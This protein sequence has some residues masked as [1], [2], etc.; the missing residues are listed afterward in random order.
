M[1]QESKPTIVVYTYK[2]TWQTRD[3]NLCV[4]FVTDIPAGHKAFEDAIKNDANIVKAMTEY[5][6]EI[7]FAF[8]NYT[9]E[10]KNIKEVDEEP[11]DEEVK[12]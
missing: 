12:N 5:V 8:I 1:K 3:G 4:K 9:R 6:N 2:Y 7:N 11:A 10:V